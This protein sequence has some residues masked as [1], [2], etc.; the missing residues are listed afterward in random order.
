MKSLQILIDFFIL[1][2]SAFLLVA[3]IICAISFN[4]FFS[5]CHFHTSVDIFSFPASSLYLVIS[6]TL[7]YSLWNEYVNVCYLFK[8]HYMFL[9]MAF[10]V[11]ICKRAFVCLD[12]V[13]QVLL[14]ILVGWAITID[15][16]NKNVACV[17]WVC[18]CVWVWTDMDACEFE[19]ISF[20]FKNSDKNDGHW[21]IH[22]PPFHIFFCVCM[23]SVVAFLLL[24]FTIMSHF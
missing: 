24:S 5:N 9:A 23:W 10:D 15:L 2:L 19:I 8:I 12:A 11:H 3:F 1:S 6:S 18:M 22:S 17:N 7:E 16:C 14:A 4:N 21:T 13:S 20:Y